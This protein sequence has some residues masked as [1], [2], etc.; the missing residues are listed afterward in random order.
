MSG[1]PA[2]LR[3]ADDG[4]VESGGCTPGYFRVVPAGTQGAGSSCGGSGEFGEGQDVPPTD[5]DCKS[6]PRGRGGVENAFSL[7]FLRCFLGREGLGREQQDDLFLDFLDLVEGD[8]GVLDDEDLAGFAVLVDAEGAAGGGLG[9]CLAEEFLA[10]EHEGEDVAGV[11]RM[12]LILLAERAEE[13]LRALLGDGL[14][15]LGGEDRA[16]G[17]AP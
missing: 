14:G 16:V 7:G 17:R 13:F 12:F 5:W 4:N 6:Q 11:F 2:T 15:I 9:A 3:G 8:V 1:F 10:L